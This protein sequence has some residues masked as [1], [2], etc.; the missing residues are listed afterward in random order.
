MIVAPSPTFEAREEGA[1]AGANVVF[2]AVGLRFEGGESMS[3]T[4]EQGKALVPSS[5]ADSFLERLAEKMGARAGASVVFGEP[6]ERGGVTVVP[7][8]RARW[9]F[10]GGAGS[11]GE[12]G[13]S[14]G[15]GGVMVSPAGYIEMKAGR[16][17]FRPIPDPTARLPVLV[18]RGA[19]LLLILGA[20]GRLRRS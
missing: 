5:R 12:G 13:G 15:G 4:N 10:G 11:R 18:A 8:A 14:G 9:G 3:L 19:L 6:V 2:R 20:L 16:A 1:A 17:R 7:V